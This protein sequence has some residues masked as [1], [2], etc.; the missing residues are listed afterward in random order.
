MDE[1][2]EHE[3]LTCRIYCRVMAP[4]GSAKSVF[5]EFQS[6]GWPS[7]GLAC[8]AALNG[9]VYLTGADSQVHLAE[10]TKNAAYVLPRSMMITAISNYVSSFAILGRSPLLLRLLQTLSSSH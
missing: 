1:H 7:A 2:P 9:P 8:L 5:T 4:R 10:E 6:N 3:A